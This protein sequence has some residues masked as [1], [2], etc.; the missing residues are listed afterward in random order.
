MG[1]CQART[2]RPYSD[3][4]ARQSD[5]QNKVHPSRTDPTN[6]LLIPIGERIVSL[7]HTQAD[8]CAERLRL[9]AGRW[10][11]ATGVLLS[12][13]FLYFVFVPPIVGE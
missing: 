4:D 8:P 2:I 13:A 5:S 1:E 11:R 7:R 6:W 12:V 3:A 10:W 9:R